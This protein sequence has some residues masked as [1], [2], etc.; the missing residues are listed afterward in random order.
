MVP[1]PTTINRCLKVGSFDWHIDPI[2]KFL[3]GKS[4]ACSGLSMLRVQGPTLGWPVLVP[5]ATLIE[6]CQLLTS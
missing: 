2:E 3:Y 4:N 6:C 5:C 1:T